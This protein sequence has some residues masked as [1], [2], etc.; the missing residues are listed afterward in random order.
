ML[1]LLAQQCGQ[2]M[3]GGE[4]IRQQGYRLEVC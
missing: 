2:Q 4:Q 3:F 1:Q